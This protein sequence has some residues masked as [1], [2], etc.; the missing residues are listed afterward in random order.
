MDSYH[1]AWLSRGSAA[2]TV[3]CSTIKAKWLESPLRN[4]NL[5]QSMRLPPLGHFTNAIR[6]QTA[7]LAGLEEAKVPAV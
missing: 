6:K 5:P 4:N 1:F 7:K 3:C 2:F